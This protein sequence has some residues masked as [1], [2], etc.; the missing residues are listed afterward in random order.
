MNA[1]RLPS[2][3]IATGAAAP[4]RPP[5]PPRPPRPPPRPP[6]ADESFNGTPGQL[7]PV[8]SHTVR[9]FF[10]GSTI[11]SSEPE[12]VRTRYQ[13]RPSASQFA[14]TA[15]LETRFVTLGPRTVSYTH[16]RAHET[17]EHLVCRLL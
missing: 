8:A 11:T 16:L 9:V 1:A 3:D 13:S 14:F 7:L 10:P 5:P 12:L 4:P 17:P 2:G 15:F 6:A